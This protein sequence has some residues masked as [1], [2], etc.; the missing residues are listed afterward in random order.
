MA[1][2]VEE[3]RQMGFD[4]EHVGRLTQLGV[5][6]ASALPVLVK[7]L[8]LATDRDDKD[9]FIRALTFRWA[10]NQALDPMIREFNSLPF[11]G[12]LADKRW[13]AGNALEVLWDDSRFDELAAIVL[14]SRFGRGRQMVAYGMR[15]SKRPEATD[16]LIRVAGDDEIGGH[17]ISSLAKLGDP[18]AQSTLQAALGHK[19]AWVRKDAKKGLLKLEQA[20]ND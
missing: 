2:A 3:V 18:R 4:V 1:S 9:T 19:E 17:A 6:Y 13:V 7:W 15:K 20:S 14:D 10:K 8:P 12:P 5:R 11:E 16:V